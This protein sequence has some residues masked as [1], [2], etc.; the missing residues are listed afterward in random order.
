MK[1]FISLLIS[2]IFMSIADSIDAIVVC[3]SLFS[4]D[5]ILKSISDIGIFTYRTERKDESAYL[6]INV[7]IGFLLGVLVFFLRNI[8]V[9]LF[10]LK[11]HG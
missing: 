4:I 1:E 11:Y 5:L 2:F 9:N 7:I 10:E 3:G 8:I 6:I